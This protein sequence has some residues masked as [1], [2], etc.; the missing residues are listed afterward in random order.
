MSI[1]NANNYR[2][3]Y[4]SRR[5]MDPQR[6]PLRASAEDFIHCPEPFRHHAHHVQ[7]E[8]RRLLDHLDESCFVDPHRAHRRSRDR[9]CTS[10]SMIDQGH[11][12]KDITRAE[13][14]NV[15][16]FDADRDFAL[17]QD[18]QVIARAIFFKNDG[19]RREFTDTVGMLE[20]VCQIEFHTKPR[21]LR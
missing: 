1:T 7:R 13:L 15:G 20:Q 9:G 18:V 16:L 4:R 3:V 11:F 5:K 21:Q 17:E 19:E 6:T 14:P 10:R 12:A 2:L 8:V